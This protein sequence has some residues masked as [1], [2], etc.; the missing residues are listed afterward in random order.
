MRA[1]ARRLLLSLARPV[2]NRVDARMDHRIYLHERGSAKTAL[3]QHLPSLLDAI[4]TQNA[5]ARELRRAEL[6]LSQSLENLRA[7]VEALE[8]RLTAAN[9]E[10]AELW[11]ALEARSDTAL[12]P[13][14]STPSS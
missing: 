12:A 4:S 14:R 5:A 7:A 11:V 1:Y 8:G 3:N 10:M 6:R 2:L 13:T 9:A